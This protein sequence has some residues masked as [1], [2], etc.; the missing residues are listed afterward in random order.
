MAQGFTPHDWL[1]AVYVA[2]WGRAADPGGLDYWVNQWGGQDE[3]G[4]TKDAAWYASN[5]ALSEEA[6]GAYPYFEAFQQGQDITPEMRG[7]FI[8]SIYDNLFNRAP[9]D[10]G[11]AY[12]LEQL[13]T[14]AVDP[15]VF[16]A[17]IVDSALVGGGADA[18]T[19][20]AKKD[21]AAAITDDVRAKGWS[22]EPRVLEYLRGDEARGLVEQTTADNAEAQKK[23]AEE[24]FFEF[25][26]GNVVLNMDPSRL[27]GEEW[28]ANGHIHNPQQAFDVMDLGGGINRINLDLGQVS[29]EDFWFNQ[30]VQNILDAV[31]GL[32]VLG[33]QSAA[34]EDQTGT[35][36]LLPGAFAADYTVSELNAFDDFV[37]IMHEISSTSV[38][39]FAGAGEELEVSIAE[40]FAGN[41]NFRDSAYEE[42]VVTADGTFNGSLA[43]GSVEIV[44]LRAED[45]FSATVTGNVVALDLQG[46][47]GDPDIHTNLVDVGSMKY[48]WL[49]MAGSGTVTIDAS[50]ANFGRAVYIDLGG[51]HDLDYT[52]FAGR[53]ETF[54]FW[55][56]YLNGDIVIQGFNTGAEEVSDRLDFGT[57]G[58]LVDSA[59]E[60][61]IQ[62]VDGNT[63][64]T[65][66]DGQFE[67]SITLV[68]V[69]DFDLGRDSDL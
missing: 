67:G 45:Q 52:A 23:A 37:S 58:S 69:T 15:G 51:D 35:T 24:R 34:W 19:I 28:K 7:A 33:L 60:L 29:M 13:E 55:E 22:D 42:I 17:A 11:K 16:I 61:N 65:A 21:V 3:Q 32:D 56:D 20:F 57:Y 47:D 30:D 59:A 5:F 53:R 54:I 62:T 68:G 14:G 40:N 9:D 43:F 18:G 48:I 31:Q 6:S 36:I 8:D 2:Y 25:G 10:E 26:D 49:D 39:S 46:E 4:R 38:T 64:I 27:M 50:A 44:E 63:L 12:W 41:L 1:S 66:A